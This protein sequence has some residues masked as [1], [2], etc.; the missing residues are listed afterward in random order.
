M[1]S[2]GEIVTFKEF[3]YVT[4]YTVHFDGKRL[5]EADEFFTLLETLEEPY[6]ESADHLVIWLNEI[7]DKYAA[8]IEFFRAE[9]EAMALPPPAEIMKDDNRVDAIRLYCYWV[10]ETIVILFNG[11]VKTE[12]DPLHCP[13]VKSHFHN[14]VRWSKQLKDI[15]VKFREKTITNR[16]QLTIEY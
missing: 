7:G 15:G 6:R 1:K 12:R 11:G 14:A 5:S 8:D 4:Y 13:N 3:E 2:F 9:R 10:S 16:S